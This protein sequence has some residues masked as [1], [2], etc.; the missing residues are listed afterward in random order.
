MNFTWGGEA[1]NPV[2]D[3]DAHSTGEDEDGLSSAIVNRISKEIRYERDE[4][5]HL[6]VVL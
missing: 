5:N 2:E 1:Y 4:K 3:G 6:L